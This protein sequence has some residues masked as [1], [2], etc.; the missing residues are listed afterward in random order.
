MALRHDLVG[1][2]PYLKKKYLKYESYQGQTIENIFTKMI[3][4][5]KNYNNNITK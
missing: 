3:N 4:I 1:A 2:L 5:Y